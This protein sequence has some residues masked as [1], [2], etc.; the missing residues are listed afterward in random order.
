MKKVLKILTLVMLILT[1]IKI[2]DTYAKYFASANTANLKHDIADWVIKVNELDIYSEGGESVEFA[3]DNLKNFSNPNAAPDKISPSSTGYDDI[4]IDPA[5]TEV[6]VRYDLELILT[7]VSD[8]PV[9][10]RLEMVESG[11]TPLVQTGEHTH[12]G[13]LSLADVK[14]GK[15]AKI[16]CYATWENDEANNEIDSMAG[17]SGTI[18]LGITVN[19]TVS[20]YLGEELTTYVEPAP[21]GEPIQDEEPTQ[22]EDPVTEPL[23]PA[24]PENI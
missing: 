5:G 16:R 13:I 19:V 3:L 1:I 6:A 8:L 14:E 2:R 10:V 15:T 11:E 4:I 9:S 17:L 24:E 22:P 12:S 23:E 21:E 18:E 20:Q 7:G